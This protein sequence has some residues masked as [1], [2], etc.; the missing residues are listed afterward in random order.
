[1]LSATVSHSC[2]GV[3]P[4]SSV[5][6]QRHTTVRICG[7]TTPRCGRSPEAA[8]ARATR[9]ASYSLA[10]VRERPALWR[11]RPGAG[12]AALARRPQTGNHV[13]RVRLRV[14][15]LEVLGR[16]APRSVGASVRPMVRGT[17]VGKPFDSSG[18]RPAAWA[19]LLAAACSSSPAAR[20]SDSRVIAPD[21]P[22]ARAACW[23]A[24]VAGNASSGLRARRSGRGRHSPGSPPPESGPYN[25]PERVAT[26]CVER[27]RHRRVK[28]SIGAASRSRIEGLGRTV[29][30]Q[31][32]AV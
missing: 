30:R 7:A 9:A 15:Q 32:P 5:S 4:R 14:R 24:G 8:S 18:A 26:G 10:A 2:A 12:Q 13:E 1:M 17:L 16:N 20:Q 3:N 29:R 11:T 6:D 19:D 28:S 27:G 22:A 23:A 25:R 21:S 31:F